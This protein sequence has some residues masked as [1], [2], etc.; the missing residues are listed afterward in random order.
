MFDDKE[1]YYSSG[2]PIR[3]SDRQ[4]WSWMTLRDS[5]AY[6]R[7][8]PALQAFQQIDNSKI[9]EFVLR[10]GIMPEIDK[11]GNLHE[12]H[13]IGAF[14]GSNALEMAAA[15]AAFANGG[16]YY[17]PY[18][19]NKV[20]F[21]NTGEEK[22]YKSDGV[23]AMSDST[24][25][26]I[27]DV[28]KSA[29]SYGLS[30][31]AAVGGV[32]VAA[33]TGTT[34]YPEDLL[35]QNGLP[36][37]IVSDSW[38]VGYDPEYSIGLWYGYPQ[39]DYNGVYNLKQTVSAVQRGRLFRAAG[40]VVFKKNG[41][42]FNIP[43]SVVKSVVEKGSWP[44]SLPSENT[45]EDLIIYEYFKVGTEPT[46]IS[47][48]Y[49]KLKNV[50][51]LSANYDPT[52]LTVKLAWSK[53]S[54]QNADESYGNFGYK[55]YKDGTYLGFTEKNYFTISDEDDP[56][57]TYK[58]VT[59]YENYDGKDSSGATVSI[60]NEASY[61]VEL[62]VPASRTYS[63]DEELDSWDIEPSSSD[64]KLFENAEEIS[65]FKTTIS[66][67]NA[68][69]DTV[70]NIT[71]NNKEEYTITYKINYNSEEVAMITRKVIIE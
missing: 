14:T 60:E 24:A 26:M 56:F 3:N 46:E 33:K 18:T 23:Y 10:L 13:S 9:K 38:V 27:T 45:P 4:Y 49:S 68:S 43:S 6:S 8:V 52:T 5:L 54:S 53:A 29:V 17:A 41:Q 63:I 70:S 51:N 64:V 32:N 35:R 67:K 7:N 20:V 21:R 28:L 47:T 42:D 66:I 2:Q 36:L 62:L 37:D 69:G 48:K 71:T 50:T 16:T 39:I 65:K 57:A 34:N 58:V 25:F 40:E 1:Y 55:V 61:T 31:A 15:Y 11:Y 22:T 44:L 59:T 19:V 12:A 30:N